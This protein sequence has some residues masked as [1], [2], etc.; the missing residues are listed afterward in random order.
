VVINATA[1][2]FARALE[3]QLPA[4]TDTSVSAYADEILDRGFRDA[5]DAQV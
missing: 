2:A 4:D 3:E 5:G 1:D